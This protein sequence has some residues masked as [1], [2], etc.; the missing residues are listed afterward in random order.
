MRSWFFQKDASGGTLELCDVP[1]P[2]P[3]H[4]ELLVEV[5]AAALNR[6]E[7]T[8]STKDTAPQTAKPCGIECAGKVVSIGVNVPQKLIATSVMGRARMAFSEYAIMRADQVMAV[9]LGMDW[10]AASTTAITYQTAYDI[11]RVNGHL[12]P[13]EWLLIT[14]ISSGVGV[15]AMQIGKL[16]GARVIGTSRSAD[17][18]EKL[19]KYG[20]DIGV[21]QNEEM[22]EQIR[23]Q[24]DGKGVDLVV[25]TVG[26]SL[27]ADCIELL[28]YQGRMGTVGYVDGIT[29]VELDIS[30]QHAKRLSLFGVSN[31]MRS[32]EENA[33]M[34]HDFIKD[35]WPAYAEG[36]LQ[37]MIDRTYSYTQL[38]E[39][40]AYMR[41]N[42]QVGKVV[43]R[44]E[45]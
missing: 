39:A 2:E 19:K 45:E 20:L 18:L 23:K 38:P 5:K 22:K 32:A 21:L 17:K 43:L 41:S 14:G 44:M 28:G 24:T 40:L 16:F 31:K 27:F 9:P 29:R 6:G 10:D 8:I 1:I 35:I 3:G 36:R 12:K 37:P 11:I 15:A 7:F 25:N 33:L 30:Q 4:G 34:V 13:G 26:G 42:E